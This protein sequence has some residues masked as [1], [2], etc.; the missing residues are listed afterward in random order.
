MRP[1]TSPSV[2][3]LD[4]VTMKRPSMRAV[5]SGL[6]SA[7]VWPAVR[8]TGSPI[9]V[10]SSSKTR[11]MVSALV[12]EL[13]CSQTITKPPNGNASIRTSPWFAIAEVT[14]RISPLPIL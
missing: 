13:N 11:H 12:P 1:T 4:Q 6:N 5:T 10:P 2:P 3:W 9:G 7:P 8:L 14:S